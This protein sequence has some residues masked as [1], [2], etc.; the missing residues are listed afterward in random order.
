[1]NV[2][3][4]MAFKPGRKEIALISPIVAKYRRDMQALVERVANIAAIGDEL[5]RTFVIEIEAAVGPAP[6]WFE[7]GR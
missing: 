2:A 3:V 1:M 6:Q 4:Q 5:E 7:P